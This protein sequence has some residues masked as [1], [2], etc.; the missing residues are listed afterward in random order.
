MILEIEL[1]GP[2]G[3]MLEALRKDG[4]SDPD[5]DVKRLVETAIHNGYQQLHE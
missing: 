1:S 2:H 3:E 5:A 4:D